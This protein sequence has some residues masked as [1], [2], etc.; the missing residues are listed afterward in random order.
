MGLN[1]IVAISA[2]GSHNVVLKSD[3]PVWAWG[4]NGVGQLGDGATIDRSLPVRVSNLTGV[5][6]IAAG[7]SHSVALKSDG[8]VMSWGANYD[9]QLGDGATLSQSLPTRVLGLSGV[10][11][12]S[13][14]DDHTLALR[15]DA[16]I[17][18]WGPNRFGQLGDGTLAD[19]STPVVVIRENGAG[20]I[21]GNDWFVDLDPAIVKAIPRE[22]I[23]VFL[24]VASVASADVT[25]TLQYRQ[26]DVGQQGN[27]YV[28]ALAPANL[29]KNAFAPALDKHLGPVAKGSSKATHTPVACVLAQ[30]SSS[31]Q[32]TAVSS[33]SLQAYLTGVLSSQGA[34]VS[35]LNGV[36]TALTKHQNAIR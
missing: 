22:K 18:S 33:S 9:G 29:V 15:S 32:L 19:R 5:V 23:P 4:A 13:A 16:S 10:V 17:M 11:A 25:A 26:Q 12:L 20:S 6:A 30:L 8:T 27:V 24:L 35:V 7:G 3:G 14:G 21:Q 34:S 1:G 2:G 36:S 28:F 31:G